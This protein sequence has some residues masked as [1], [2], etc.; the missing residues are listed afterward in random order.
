MP[1]Q[2]AYNFVMLVRLPYDNLDAGI[3]IYF[4]LALLCSEEPLAISSINMST[5]N[6]SLFRIYNIPISVLHFSAY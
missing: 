3:L 5:L 4:I 1:P 6:Y 2:F